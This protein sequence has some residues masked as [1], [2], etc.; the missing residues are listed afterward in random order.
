VIIQQKKWR[1]L[2]GRAYGLTRPTLVGNIKVQTAD[3][4]NLDEINSLLTTATDLDVTWSEIADKTQKTPAESLMK[5]VLFW[6]DHIQQKARL[7]LFSPGLIIDNRTV[8]ETTTLFQVALPYNRSRTSIDALTWLIKTINAV[9]IAQNDA[10]IEKLREQAIRSCKRLVAKLQQEAP[11]GSNALRFL[12]AADQLGIPWNRVTENVFEYGYGVHLRWLDSSFSDQTSVIGARFA[13]NKNS[14]ATILRQA[15]L[16]CPEHFLVNNAA[17][18]IKLAQRLKYP[19]VIKPMDKDR[20][21]GVAANLNSDEEV[22]EAFNKARK[23]SKKILVEKHIEGQDYRLT[24]LNGKMIWAVLRKPGGVVG[25]GRDN[26]ATLIDQLNDDPIRQ[27]HIHALLKTLKLDEEAH[28]LLAQAA[29]TINDVP[30][31][32]QFVQLRRTAN[33]ST[34]GTPT[35]AIDLVHPDNRRLVENAA[36]ALKLDLAGIDLIIPD[37]S[38]S[39]L[40]IE[41]GICEV[42][43]QPQLGAITYAKIYDEIL[44]SLVT[45]NGRIPI[46]LIIGEQ[47]AYDVAT[48]LKLQWQAAD[49]QVAVA[50]S[51]GVWLNNDQISKSDNMFSASQVALKTASVDALIVISSAPEIERFGLAFDYCDVVVMADRGNANSSLFKVCQMVFSQNIDLVVVNDNDEQTTLYAKQLGIKNIMTSSSPSGLAQCATNISDWPVQD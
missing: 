3:S 51:Q 14:T 2:K 13:R 1:A 45:N 38:Q 49:K 37:I 50:S 24:V 34:G 18:A 42:N 10:D 9:S 31:Q 33:I 5:L 47:S 11:S 40:D 41:A 7:P 39:W 15:G 12:K 30:E 26:I 21:L 23:I 36:A 16:P 28:E 25:N 20:G 17:S 6:L 48:E 4:D 44:T 35:A 19:V 43:A 46:A 27:D 22:R 8:N 32:G 29:L